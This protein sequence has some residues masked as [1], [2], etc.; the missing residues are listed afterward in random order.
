MKN[1]IESLNEYG[2]S[3]NEAQL[4]SH[5]LENQ[6]TPAYDISQKTGIP[7][8]TVYKTLESMKKQGFVSSWIKNGVKHFSVENPE[9]LRRQLKTKEQHIEGVFPEMMNLFNLRLTHPSAKLYEGK[10][11]VKQVF[12]QMFEIIKQQRL[13]RIYV[14]SDDNIIKQIP[15]YYRQWRDRKD[16]LGTFTQL[17]VPNGTPITNDFKSYETRETRILPESFPFEGGIDIIGSLVVFI[18]FKNNQIYAVTID[19]IIISEMMVK[20]FTYIWQTLEKRD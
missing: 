17:I 9:I 2:F 10:A 20:L 5:L 14:F 16:K 3:Q 4:Y 13:K 15:D 6:D 1:I 8:T 12:E 11:G 7:R 18:S 19:S